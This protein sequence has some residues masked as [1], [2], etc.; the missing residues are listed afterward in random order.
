MIRFVGKQEVQHAT[1]ES[2]VRMKTLKYTEKAVKEN[3]RLYNVVHYYGTR[4]AQ[5]MPQRPTEY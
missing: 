2:G 3:K 1:W 4:S 5:I